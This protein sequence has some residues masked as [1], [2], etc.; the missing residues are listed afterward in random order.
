MI[1]MKVIQYL[2]Q[3]LVAG[4]RGAFHEQLA[5]KNGISGKSLI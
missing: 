4:F 2:N 3:G 1:C 5:T